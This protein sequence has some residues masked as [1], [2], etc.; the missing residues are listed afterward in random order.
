MSNGESDVHH[1]E[2]AGDH[3]LV[4]VDR[5]GYVEMSV[6]YPP[7]SGT[8]DSDHARRTPRQ[9]MDLVRASVSHGEPVGTFCCPI[10][11]SDTP[12]SHSEIEQLIER[13][14]RPAFESYMHR[15][16]KAQSPVSN[17]FKRGYWLGYPASFAEARRDGG[18]AEREYP[19]GPYRSVELQAA[20]TIWLAS[21][22]AIAEFRKA[23]GGS[24]P[25]KEASPSSAE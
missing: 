22:M 14:A 3:W 18:W 7:F 6:S 5:H 15:Q 1:L 13:V 11:G 12:H 17:M 21:W 4:R 19:T 10:C 23:M 9:W 25:F 24:S 20:W 8:R 16:H 2:V